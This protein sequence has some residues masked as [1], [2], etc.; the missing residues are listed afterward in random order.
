MACVCRAARSLHAACYPRAHMPGSAQ[1]TACLQAKGCLSRL[2]RH[3]ALQCGILSRVVLR[4]CLP[5]SQINKMLPI[6]GPGKALTARAQAE[7]LFRLTGQKEN[8]ISAPVGLFDAIIGM[9]DF[10][11]KYFPK[12]FEV[13]CLTA[14]FRTRVARI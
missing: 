9:L 1:Q 5:H 7:I 12:Q 10:L 6:G 14:C 8:F 13:S 3:M 4:P 2:T 11:A